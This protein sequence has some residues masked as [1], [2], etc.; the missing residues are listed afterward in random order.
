MPLNECLNTGPR[1]P[2]A[3]PVS[4]S[5]YPNQLFG[6]TVASTVNGTEAFGA[7]YRYNLTD[8]TMTTLRQ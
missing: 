7:L 2:I 5:F 3:E 1:M 4:A 8:N 6:T